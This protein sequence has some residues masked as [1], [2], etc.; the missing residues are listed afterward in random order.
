[1]NWRLLKVCAGAIALALVFVAC[2]SGGD[3][4]TDQGLDVGFD[5]A[6]ELPIDS[7]VVYDLFDE[8]VNVSD[9]VDDVADDIPTTELP[10]D[11]SVDVD[12]D[13]SDA[14]EVSPDVPVVPDPALR[15]RDGGWL[16]GDLHMHSTYSDGEDSVA[17]TVGLAEYFTDP[18]FLAFHP[19]YDGF[20]LDYIALTDHR[21][22]VQNLDPDFVS[23]KVVLIPGEEFGGPGHACLF[24]VTDTVNHNANG[25]QTTV[26]DYFDGLEV[27]GA[28]GAVR[29]INHPFTTGIYF[30]WDLHNYDSMEIW[31][32][33]WAVSQPGASQATI[34]E[35]EVQKGATASVQFRRA[36][37][38]QGIGGNA[39]ALK[40]YEVLLSRGH[41]IA[42]VGGSDRHTVFGIGFPATWIK[43]TSRDVVGILDAIRAR[44]T[45]VNRTPVA[46]TIEMTVD[47][48]TETYMQG[49]QIPIPAEGLEVTISLRTTRAAGG[50]LFLIGGHAIASDEELA[51]AIIS[52]NDLMVAV[53]TDD[54]QIEYKTT[55]MPGDWF[56]PVVHEPLVQPG[57]DPVLTA[58]IPEIAAT[59]AQISGENYSPLIGALFPY[60]D[61]LT[62][63]SPENCDPAGW[64]ADKAQCMPPDNNGMATIMLP[65]WIDRVLNVVVENGE[66][67]TEWCMGAAASAVMFVAES[68]PE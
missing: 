36:A 55:V 58:Q 2:G 50:R 39:Q 68:V 7:D 6:G 49:D 57:L 29:S 25:G 11:V 60:V 64:V 52:E 46:A 54:F 28:M 53:E 17:V 30:P 56:Y 47:V 3:D 33:K 34:D 18:D 10:T 24:G 48:G 22:A 9:V 5:A 19:A 35:W 31:N 15:L 62:F 65:D 21:T 4:G 43:S 45:F 41:H 42:V 23:E 51:G 1:M 16:I 32:V 59:V 13:A 40:F 66:S 63:M 37:D 20:A 8:D 67:S 14:L 12:L 38:F 27:A 61:D 26:E 44:H